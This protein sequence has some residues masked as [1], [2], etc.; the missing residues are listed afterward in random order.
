[1][2]AVLTV[3]STIVI[4]VLTPH[5]LDELAQ[6]GLIPKAADLSIED[7]EL[8]HLLK[9]DGMKMKRWLNTVRTG[10]MVPLRNLQGPLLDVLEGA[11]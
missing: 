7:H 6:R 10:G 8:Q 11:L 5:L 2:I 3:G 1:M 9:E 4:G